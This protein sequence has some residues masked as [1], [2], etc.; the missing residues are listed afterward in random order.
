MMGG[1][2]PYPRMKDSGVAWLG[3]VPAYLARHS[4]ESGNP[5]LLAD[6]RAVQGRHSLDLDFRL[7]GNDSVGCER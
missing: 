1:L 4:R 6:K 5:Q 7:R 3:D 2:K